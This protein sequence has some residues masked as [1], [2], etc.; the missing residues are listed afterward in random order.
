[1]IKGKAWVFG[2]NIEG[3][4]IVPFAKVRDHSV[5]NAKE[6]KG[7]CMVDINPDFPK[8]AKKED[9]LIAG[10][11]FG[12]E[13]VHVHAIVALK[14]SISAV[15]AESVST[16][17]HRKAIALGLRILEC[18]DILQHFKEGNEIEVDLQI[19]RIKNLTTG[20]TIRTTTFPDFIMEI[21]DVGSLLEYLKMRIKRER[22]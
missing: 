21:L 1:M 14:E 20:K 9:I 5:I 19:G 22:I 15:I 8:K 17:M 11:N 10:K 16:A 12:G 7:L 4:M 3:D 2:N 18:K 6:L 13:R